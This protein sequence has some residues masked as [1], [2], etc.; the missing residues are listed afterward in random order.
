MVAVAG[1]VLYAAGPIT[2][3]IALQTACR[4]VSACLGFQL[5]PSSAGTL[6]THGISLTAYAIYTAVVLT[7][8]WLL[9]YGLA[10]LIILR[11]AGDRGAVLAAFFLVIFPV[12]E[13]SVWLPSGA[14]SFWLGGIFIPLLLVF[15]LLFPDGRFRPRWARWLAV[16]LVLFFVLGSFPLPAIVNNATTVVFILLFF[17]VVAA[18]IHR[19][20]SISS[21]AEQ[22]QTK[23]GVFGL[24]VAILGFIA[25]LTVSQISSLPTGN[26]SLYAAL[27]DSSGIAVLLSAIPLSIG[28]A[29]L[30][31]RL[32]DIDRVINRALVYAV[33]TLTLGAIYVGGVIGLQA[34][35]R[36][37]AGNSS[38]LAIALSTLAIAALFR[39]LRH[40]IQNGID[41]RFYRTKYDTQRI[42]A[43]FGERLQNEVD[44]SQLSQ[45]LT[46]VVHETLHPQHVSLWLRVKEKA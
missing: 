13:V 27:T 9:W 45:D 42:L 26:G 22:Q 39:P 20:R 5:D 37:V 36:V 44:L 10:A 28:I 30:R 46:S 8:V 29:V 41:R 38:G 25:L 18:Q 43:S 34:L 35:F 11:K 16:A 32:W 7:A 15:G 17:G 14:L 2:Q 6:N 31:N 33:L 3:W 1:T 24:A 4:P 40:R 21:W 23:W 12:Y 19:Y